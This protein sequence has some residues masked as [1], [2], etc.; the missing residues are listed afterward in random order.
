MADVKIIENCAACPFLAGSQCEL[1]SETEIDMDF[2]EEDMPTTCALLDGKPHEKGD[3][4]V[5]AAKWL[6]GK[7]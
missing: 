3:I 7:K 4:V 6:L 5:G 2:I 1:D